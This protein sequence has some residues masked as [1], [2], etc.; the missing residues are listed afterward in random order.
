MQSHQMTLTIINTMKDDEEV[1]SYVLFASLNV[2]MLLVQ[3]PD[4]CDKENIHNQ[5]DSEL[6]V[7]AN[8]QQIVDAVQ[9]PR[10]HVIRY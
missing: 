9:M 8:T 7:E 4:F 5:S 6:L 10:S 2:I 1:A 3:F